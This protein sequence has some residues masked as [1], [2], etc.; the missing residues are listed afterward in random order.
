MHELFIVHTH[1]QISI[2][3]K[4]LQV[5]MLYLFIL[6]RATDSSQ[7]EPNSSIFI[8]YW[9]QLHLKLSLRL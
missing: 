9:A 1:K 2:S 5:T 4:I 3:K 7:F 8:V 6:F